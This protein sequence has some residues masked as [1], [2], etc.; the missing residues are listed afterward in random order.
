VIELDEKTAP[1]IQ[2]IVLA[3]RELVARLEALEAKAAAA[4]PA[5]AP[6]VP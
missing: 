2:D 4:P 5:P 1:G 3:V 6:P